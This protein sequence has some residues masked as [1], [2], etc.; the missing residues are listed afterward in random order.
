M[1]KARDNYWARVLFDFYIEKLLRKNFSHFYL[2]NKFPVLNSNDSIILTPNHFSWWDGFFLD[3][4][5]KH[6]T[7]YKIKLMM[8]HEQ[9]KRY[10]FFKY[11][12]AYSINP[13]NPASI[14]DAIKYTCSLLNEERNGII[15][16]PQGNIEPYEKRPLQLKGGLKLIL[17]S[18]D[19]TVIIPVGFKIHYTEEK[20]PSI[21]CRFGEPISAQVVIND[22]P[23]FTETFL[24][25][26]NLL[27]A[28]VCQLNVVKDYFSDL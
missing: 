8:L 22:F 11:V 27:D 19:N 28:S 1:I 25:N 4:I 13:G 9:L 2:L 14:K 6:E 21:I 3:W 12:G 17:K 7:K 5:L 15:I 26:L 16:Y 10:W 18:K 23:L 24:K 20:Y